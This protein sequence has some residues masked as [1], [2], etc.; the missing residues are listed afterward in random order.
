[1]WYIVAMKQKGS[2]LFLILL[3]MT[4]L[5][6]PVSGQATDN[7]VSSPQTPPSSPPSL[8]APQ[9]AG[10]P[11]VSSD[12][13]GVPCVYPSPK[14]IVANPPPAPAPEP[15]WPLQD[16]I[17]WAANLVLAIV[18]YAGVVLAVSTLKKIER[19]TRAT[20]AVA[21]AATRSA[22]AALLT[23]QA[24]I[25]S[26]RPWILISVKPSRTIENS[27]T[28]IA[29]NRGRSPAKIIAAAEQI[30][31]A[32]DEAHLPAAPEYRSEEPDAMF[33]PIILL[34]GESTTIRSFG[35]DDVRGL[36]DSDETFRKVENWEEKVYIY[37]KILYLDMIASAGQQTHMS[38]WCCWYI[39][40]RQN[41]SLVIAG[42]PQYNVHT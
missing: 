28:V 42:P 19:S 27:F 35:R 39:H 8:A 14:I 34:P 16:R 33:V 41:S 7:P 17:A 26:G 23:A 6:L 40:G 22:E 24:I 3:A 37:G 18:G 15:F 13:G 32:I 4:Q 31:I 25:E 1:M 11:G 9:S 36:C 21:E 38:A 5:P 20:E 2:A 12:C 30:M 10:S 29:T